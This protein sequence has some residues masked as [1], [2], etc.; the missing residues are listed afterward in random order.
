LILEIENMDVE[1][2]FLH[3]DLEEEISMKQL[4]GFVVNGKNDLACKLK[5]SIYGLKKSPR[6][7]YQTFDTHILSLGFLRS[8][9]DHCI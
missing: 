8:N 5:I 1:T 9:V 7:W 4:E 3:E 2:M 6:M